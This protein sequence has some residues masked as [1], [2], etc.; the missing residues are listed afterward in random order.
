MI[1]LGIDLG[2]TKIEAALLDDTGQVIWRHRIP[3]P[4]H[5]YASTLTAIGELVA[6]ADQAAANHG[7]SS[8]LPHVG[9]GLGT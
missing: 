6:L 1:R 4:Q 5:H 3:S 7:A 2:G 8:P 9:I